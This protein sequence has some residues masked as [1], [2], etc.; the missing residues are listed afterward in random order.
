MKN[1]RLDD[2]T[3]AGGLR[4]LLF[5]FAAVA[6]IWCLFLLRSHMIRESTMIIHTPAPAA[7]ASKHTHDLMF[8]A[9]LADVMKQQQACRGPSNVDPN[10]PIVSYYLRDIRMN[11]QQQQ[12]LTQLDQSTGMLSLTS[13]ATNYHTCYYSFFKREEEA[14]NY[15]AYDD[16]R[17]LSKGMAVQMSR[18]RMLVN[19][20]CYDNMGIRVYLNTH[21]F[22]PEIM[23]DKVSS[24]ETPSV[25]VFFLESLPQL[26][27]KRFMNQTRA[28]LD[29][30][31]SVQ[32]LD[33]F[34][35]PLDNSFPNTIAFLTGQRVPWT[36][37]LILK[38]SYFDRQFKYLW[39]DFKDAGYVTAFEE[40]LAV[41]GVFNYGK[42]GFRT[43]PCDFNPRSFWVQMYPETGDFEINRSM[44]DVSELCFHRNGPKISSFFNHAKEF[45]AKHQSRP[46]FAFYF[47]SQMTH[48]NF[49]KFKLADGFV[50]DFV[51]DITPLLNHTILLFAGDH[52]FRMGTFVP[53]SMGRI[54][55]RMNLVS[56]RIPD[57]V[58]QRYPHLRR[59]LEANRHAL[60]SWYDVHAMIK[61][62]ADGS[63]QHH[64]YETKLTA[65]VNPATQF[66]SR[67][68]TSADANID[69]VYCV[70]NDIVNVD[71]LNGYRA[72]DVEVAM[73]AVQAFLTSALKEH[74][75]PQIVNATI[76]FSYHIPSL[77][78]HFTP[79][80]HA[81]ITVLL[82]PSNL[83]FTA[84]VQRDWQEDSEFT[85]RIDDSS[86]DLADRVNVLQQQLHDH[87]HPNAR[88][89]GK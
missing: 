47:Y 3:A 51:R 16:V 55:E 54:E 33:Y 44:S 78:Q 76:A 35:K 40:D 34:V 19:T 5:S 77:P 14:D 71:P 57:S 69:D 26:S 50:A 75:C 64:A 49:N 79:I 1:R 60:V 27:F 73:K 39:D 67:R 83:T 66:I 86:R 11:C 87:C 84:G 12:P 38:K 18:Q 17:I 10:D 36:Q 29:D 72:W 21:L 20:S 2:A 74:P 89:R 23:S 46:Y 80:E 56:V 32:Y 42:H 25:F 61:S 52:G 65:P 28:A 59:Y 41:V 45:L 43:S 6:F 88:R 22:V 15:I 62:I 81:D 7:D 82:K 13:A 48:D 37:E 30:L 31:G 4:F 53:T 58:H 9:K 68:R 70:C 85:F 63:F 8:E 24:A